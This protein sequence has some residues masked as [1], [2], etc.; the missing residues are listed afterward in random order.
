[1]SRKGIVYTAQKGTIEMHDGQTGAVT[2]TLNY[3]EG[4]YFD[5]LWLMPNG[6]LVTSWYDNSDDIV[7]FDPQG[8]VTTTISK[9]IST[10]TGDSELDTKVAADGTGNIYAAGSFN[11]AVF[12]FSPDGA[13]QDKFGGEGDGQGQFRAML[14]I[15]VDG[16]GQVYVADFKGVQIFSPD[17]QYKGLIDVDGPS[18][19]LS[20]DDANHL[21]VAAGT[22]VVEYTLNN[23]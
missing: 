2:G 1:V 4:N 23:Q 21:W 15:A 13:F 5:S 19:G 3:G 14:A 16:Q 10:V 18:Y 20:V 12:K 9:A 22:Q 11:N 8:N 7:V 17:G 6:T